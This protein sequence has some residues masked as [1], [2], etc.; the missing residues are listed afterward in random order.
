MCDP[1]T[2]AMSGL[3][4]V[5]SM[6]SISAQNSAAA[7]NHANSIQAM[8]D[9]IAQEQLSF[10][11]RNRSL[12]QGGFDAIL[13]GREAESAAY[14][15][16]IQNGVQGNSVKAMLR[17]TRRKTARNSSRTT[18]EMESLREQTGANLDHIHTTASGRINSV[19]TTSFGFGDLAGVLSPIVKSEL[20]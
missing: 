14:A 2:M 7:Q 10:S 6:A 15:S 8:N 18:Q 9:S 11:E 16:A 20:E 5:Q 1:I 3:N 4:A 13:E 17:D 12:L 19:P